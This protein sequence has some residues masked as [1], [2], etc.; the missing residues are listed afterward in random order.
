MYKKLTIFIVLLVTAALVSP[1]VKQLSA[2]TSDIA[3]T[4]TPTSGEVMVGQQF[5]VTIQL[6]NN[7]GQPYDGLDVVLSY[8]PSELQV[9]DSNSSQSGIQIE[10]AS[11]LPSVVRNV[12]NQTTGTIEFSQIA[13]LGQSTTNEGDVATI[14]FEALQETNAANVDFNFTPGSTVDSNVSYQGTDVL[15]S[16]TDAVYSITTLIRSASLSLQTSE[17]A[18]LNGVF[19]VDVYLDSNVNET[20]GVDVIITFDPSKLEV[21]DANP[22]AS[23]TQ[24]ASTQLLPVTAL[25]QVTNGTITFSQLIT[26]GSPSVHIDGVIAKITFKALALGTTDIT[27]DFDGVGATIDSNVAWQTLDVLN[28]VSNAQITVIESPEMNLSKSASA[29]EVFVGQNITYTITYTNTG[30]VNSYNTVIQ[31]VLDANVEYVS[32]SGGTY[33]SGTHSINWNLNTVAPGQSGQVT[34]TVRAL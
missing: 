20:D 23:G 26:Q 4:I 32:S 7:S 13:S 12:V 8:N 19:E 11:L 33:Q 22:N 3:L 34:V 9:I 29:S 21:V 18:S 30:D 6:D 25:N 24:I 31:D 10:P 16:V 17:I 1:A 2:Q 15:A 27:L 5:E 14:T 28:E